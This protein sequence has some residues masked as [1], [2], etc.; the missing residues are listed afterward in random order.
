MACKPSRP[1]PSPT[2]VPISEPETPAEPRGI[3]ILIKQNQERNLDICLL[4]VGQ[5]YSYRVPSFPVF[6]ANIRKMK[7]KV[8]S[9]PGVYDGFIRDC[10]SLERNYPVLTVVGEGPRDC[11]FVSEDEFSQVISLNGLIL[12][13]DYVFVMWNWEWGENVY[14]PDPPLEIGCRD[15]DMDEA[16]LNSK[17][18][19]DSEVDENLTHAVVF[20]CIGSNK[21]SQSQEVLK[22]VS[23]KIEM[24]TSQS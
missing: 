10:P 12:Y 6:T 20:K 8:S 24:G 9:D 21:D 22:S 5:K 2:P 14:T 11:F 17:P 13:D 15:D 3:A 19:S 16:S 7:F 23:Q 4:E 18:S 1:M